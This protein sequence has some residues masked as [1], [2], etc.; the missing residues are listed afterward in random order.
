MKVSN[1]LFVL[2][3]GSL[4]ASCGAGASSSSASEP[5]GT[6]SSSSASTSSSSSSSSASSSSSE[7]STA[8]STTSIDVAVGIEDLQ[9]ASAKAK[10]QAKAIKGGIITLSETSSFG[11]PTKKVMPFEFGSDK[12]GDVLHYKDFDWSM[13]EQD[14]YIMKDPSGSILG[15]TKASD[16]TISKQYEQYTEVQYAFRNLLGYGEETLYGTEGLLEG[17]LGYAQRNVNQDAKF[18]GKNGIYEFSF[19]YFASLDTYEFYTVGASFSLGEKDELQAMTA[20]ISAYNQSSFIVDDE[21]QTI[22]L[23]NGATPT[24]TKEYQITQTIGERTFQNPI[25][26]DSFYATSFDL[27]YEG[28]SVAE[29]SSISVE[30]GG[31]VSIGL[32]NVLPETANFDFDTVTVTVTGGEEGGLSGQ[33]TKYSQAISLSPSAVGEYRVEVKSVHVTK[34]F[35]VNV[36]AAQPNNIG[37]SYFV[38]GPDGYTAYSYSDGIAGYVKVT[39]IIA[40]NI[41]PDAAN[42]EVTTSVF[43]AEASAYKIERKEIRVNEWTDPKEMICFT[44]LVAGGFDIT[45]AS[46]VN[47]AVAAT[48]HITASPT[49]SIAAV[50][51]SQFASRMGGTIKYVV[52]FTPSPSVDGSSGSIHIEDKVSKKSE[53]ATYTLAKGEKFYTFTLTHVSGESFGLTFKMSFDFSLFYFDANGLANQMSKVTPE[54][55][56]QGGWTAT[57]GNYTFSF[58]FYSTG[59]ASMMVNSSDF[60][61]S[62][63]FSCSYTLTETTDGYDGTFTANPNTENPFVTLPLSFKVD[64]DFTKVDTSFSFQEKSYT[65]SFVPESY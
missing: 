24:S 43:G 10:A 33:F 39:Y 34:T 16:G 23:L 22:Q 51:S 48:V 5:V 44:P 28:A 52:S 42:Q 55:W 56:I 53:D 1:A 50:L 62:E 27:T 49:P 40:A 9:K 8:S 57:S 7:S 18:D 45:I 38:E 14:A 13:T 37:I 64:K 63:Y 59:E 35:Q 17:L 15:I 58:Q 11:G 61:V 32:A 29:G 60:T 26:L 6:S 21:L 54:F 12:N 19:G 41:L 30:T 36:T 46:A 2:A 20:K 47:P 31:D 25:H 3:L 65:L 4:L